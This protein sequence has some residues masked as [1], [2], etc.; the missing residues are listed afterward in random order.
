MSTLTTAGGN[1]IITSVKMWNEDIDG[2][3]ARF[4]KKLMT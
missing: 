3:F 4:R 2:E 1:S